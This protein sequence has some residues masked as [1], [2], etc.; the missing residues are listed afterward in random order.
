MKHNKVEYDWGHMIWLLDGEQ[1]SAPALSTAKM[2]MHPKTISQKH[3]HANC[4]EFIV[5]NTGEVELIADDQ[6]TI[7]KAEDT[8]LIHPNTTHYLINNSNK[9]VDMMIIYSAASRNYS[10][11]D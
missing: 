4:H 8:Y 2:I 9:N 5:V 7:L 11:P 3:F 10:I 6:S 1:K